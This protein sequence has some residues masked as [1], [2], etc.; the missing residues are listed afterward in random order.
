MAKKFTDEQVA[1]FKQAFALF[2]TD[3]NGFVTT[4]ELG[5]VMRSLGQKPTGTFYINSFYFHSSTLHPN[6]NHFIFN[7]YSHSILLFSTYILALITS[8]IL[9]INKSKSTTK[10]RLYNKTN[11]TDEEI[12]QMINVVDADGDGTIDFEEFIELMEI[13]MNDSDEEQD[14]IEVFKVFDGDGNGYIT[15]AEL[16][17]VMTNLEEELTEEEVDE[18]IN[19]ADI[20]GDGQISYN[21]FKKM[22][23]ATGAVG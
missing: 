10:N 4:D 6:I 15:A 23:L 21:E 18:M 16:R 9:Y 13:R 8:S 7:F 11:K 1:E 22:M 19:E 2:D 17:H 3:G 5:T 20:D 12:L 14:I